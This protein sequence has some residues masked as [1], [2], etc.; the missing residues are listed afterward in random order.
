M[1]FNVFFTLL[2]AVL[3]VS[4]DMCLVGIG[5]YAMA[6]QLADLTVQL[7]NTGDNTEI[8]WEVKRLNML[9]QGNIYP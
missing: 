8:F 6:K 3:S 2:Q 9:K 7:L 5:S 1:Y 4:A